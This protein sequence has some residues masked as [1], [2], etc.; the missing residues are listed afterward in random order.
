[1]GR[2]I[3]GAAGADPGVE[4]V[5]GTV[6]PG[7]G[8]GGDVGVPVTDD[9]GSVLRNADVLIDFT[10]PE[11]TMA[12]AR[13][14]AELGKAVVVGT[15]GL[16]TSQ[17]DELRTLAKRAPVFYSRNMSVGVNALLKYLPSLV[18][19]LAGYDVEITEAHHRH[20]KDAPSGTALAIAES[21]AE[22]LGVKL[23][24]VAVYERHGIAPREQ[25]QIG[26]QAIRAG[27]N[28][29]EHTILVADEGEEIKVIHRAYSRR[30]FA[31]G[32]LRAARWTAGKPPGYYT[33]QDLLE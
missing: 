30:T 16:S 26:I 13:A 12:N 24:D 19:A 6:R 32:A 18:R 31:L 21:L 22:A 15:T 25:G 3:I 1:M 29:G 33:M 28:A 2:E 23:D 4:I 10:T 9:L 8:K 17:I 5:G 11:V 20:K 27:G 7:S 14:A